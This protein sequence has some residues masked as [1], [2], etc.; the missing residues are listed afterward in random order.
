MS[1]RRKLCEAD[2][3]R[4]QRRKCSPLITGEG[5]AS[6]DT[7][8]M[9]ATGALQG[10]YRRTRPFT[11]TRAMRFVRALRSLLLNWRTPKP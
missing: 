2:L 5:G 8:Q 4:A 7:E 3:D 11:V 10:P 6:I 1:A 9:L